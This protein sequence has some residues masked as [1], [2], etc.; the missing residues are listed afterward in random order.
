MYVGRHAACNSIFIKLDSFK[1][2][3]YSNSWVKCKT[4]FSF[5]DVAVLDVNCHHFYSG[6]KIFGNKVLLQ[7]I[8]IKLANQNGLAELCGERTRN[9]KIF[10][11]KTIKKPISFRSW[12]ERKL[13]WLFS[14]WKTPHALC[15]TWLTK[16]ELTR[17]N[18]VF[19]AS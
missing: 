3:N 5:N 19:L 18:F 8:L 16:T 17:C 1:V 13:H 12:Q 7:N 4:Y 11:W 9:K 6:A 15:R 2:M 14:A 10:P